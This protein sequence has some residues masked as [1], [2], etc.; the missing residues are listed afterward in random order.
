VVDDMGNVEVVPQAAA[1]TT[2]MMLSVE[3]RRLS[4]KLLGGI[5]KDGVLDQGALRILLQMAERTNAGDAPV[6]EAA[7]PVTPVAESE[8]AAPR[9]SRI[10]AFPYHLQPYGNIVETERLN[11]RG[12]A[13]SIFGSLDAK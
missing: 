12:A 13:T 11:R 9:R 1:A 2:A 8:A 4:T 10:A 6:A 3:Q 7:A 5:K